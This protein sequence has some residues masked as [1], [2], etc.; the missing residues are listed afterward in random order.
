VPTLPSLVLA[1]QS[2]ELP[3]SVTAQGW[4]SV[5]TVI[6]LFG[7]STR[8]SFRTSGPVGVSRALQPT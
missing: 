1:I 3:S 4:M 8:W 7:S 2:H 6:W 5:A